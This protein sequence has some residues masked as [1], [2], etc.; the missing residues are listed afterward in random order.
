MA[1]CPRDTNARIVNSHVAALVL[2]VLLSMM[3]VACGG[4]KS[5]M[6][7]TPVVPVCQSNNTAT[8]T[9][10]NRTANRTHDLYLD[11]ANAALL[12]PGQTSRAFTVAAGVQHSVVWRYTNTYLSACVT[13]PIP[14]VCSSQ[15]YFCAF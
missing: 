11:N 15:L 5:A 2:I 9:F 10:E 4:S 13:T 14:A 3:T 7:P 6:A 12:G 8:L 1:S